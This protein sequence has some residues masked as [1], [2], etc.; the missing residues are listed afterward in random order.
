MATWN[1][2]RKQ[3]DT[4]T[5]PLSTRRRT[6]WILYIGK[7]F[8]LFIQ[9]SDKS[10]R[11]N[12]SKL[13]LS[14]TCRARPCSSGNNWRQKKT[15]YE[16]I[17]KKEAPQEANKRAQKK[18]E[19]F[20]KEQTWLGMKLT[21]KEENQ[22]KE[23]L[24]LFNKQNHKHHLKSSNHFWTRKQLFLKI[25]LPTSRRKP[26]DKPIIEEENEMEVDRRWKR[27][28]RHIKH[29]KKT[30]FST[31]CRRARYYR[32]HQRKNFWTSNSTVAK[33]ERHNDPTNGFW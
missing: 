15:P 24:K 6:D 2:P 28:Q 4:A 1:Y 11:R 32:N 30:P 16:T 14:N 26:I 29:N 17:G 31:L 12:W 22:I 10:V 5:L 25:S 27:F 9:Y 3:A 8:L 21:R 18:F 33:P 23:K 20:P 13:E 7:R 19:F